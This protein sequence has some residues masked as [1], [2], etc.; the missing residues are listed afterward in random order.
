MHGV[1]IKIT[2]YFVQKYFKIIWLPT[3]WELIKQYKS[4]VKHNLLFIMPWI[5]MLLFLGPFSGWIME[6][7]A[8]TC[9][10]IK[11][12]I[13]KSCLYYILLH[14][15][16]NREKYNRVVLPSNCEHTAESTHWHTTRH[17]SR[18]R[19]HRKVFGTER[20]LQ[21]LNSQ[22]TG[23]A[24]TPVINTNSCLSAKKI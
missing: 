21:S 24:M 17:H 20:T 13:K 19:G 6:G 5:Y 1:C 14:N 22:G 2:S 8:G 18:S 16:I 10:F 9:K 11:Y 7:V 3:Y 15:L 23:T 4:T 12:L